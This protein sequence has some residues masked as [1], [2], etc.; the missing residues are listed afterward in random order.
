MPEAGRALIAR[1]GV[2][3]RISTVSGGQGADYLG[4][5]CRAGHCRDY[6]R[7][8]SAEGAGAQTQPTTKPLFLA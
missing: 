1:H 8:N 7:R 5:V 3:L 2:C 4:H 6:D